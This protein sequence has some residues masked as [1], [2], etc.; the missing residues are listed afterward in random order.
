MSNY[1]SFPS[2]SLPGKVNIALN[3]DAGWSTAVLH[4]NASSLCT[5]L[6]LSLADLHRLRELV[7]NAILQLAA[8][9]E[10]T[11]AAAEGVK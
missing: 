8:K 1:R 4:V 2:S 10:N 11:D 5:M 9:E 3:T 6:N 7:D